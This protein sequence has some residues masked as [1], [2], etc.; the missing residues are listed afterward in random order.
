MNLFQIF[1][2]DPD[3]LQTNLTQ[4]A[5]IFAAKKQAI[6]D[7]YS[8]NYQLY[9]NT[10]AQEFLGKF[11]REVLK[12]FNTLAP[13]AFRAD[14]LRYCLLYE[15][16]GWYFD[17]SILP[18][19]KVEPT[20]ENV[21]FVSRAGQYLEN[22]MLYSA[23]REAYY[24]KLINAVCV[25]VKKRSDGDFR[26]YGGQAVLNVTGPILMRNVYLQYIYK[27]APR[28]AVEIRKRFE[29]GEYYR[30]DATEGRLALASKVV[31]IYKKDD[32]QFGR[33]DFIGFVG[34]NNYNQLYSKK[35]VYHEL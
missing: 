20:T 34:T 13:Y 22:M 31:A 10:E 1:L 6:L 12:A 23:P 7:V 8:G 19:V 2:C 11:D 14:L 18:I 27:D 5:D 33:I 4:C 30:P 25:N 28:K 15:Y 29:F 9:T 3:K 32:T 35:A 21:V 17:Q 26:I 24:S 16:G